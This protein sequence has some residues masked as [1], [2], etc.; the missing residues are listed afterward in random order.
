MSDSWIYEG[1][2]NLWSFHLT[3]SGILI[4]LITVLYSFLLNKREQYLSYIH[5]SRISKGPIIKKRLTLTQKYIQDI[6]KVIQHCFILLIISLIL[7]AISI[8]TSRL[9]T[10]LNSEKIIYIIILSITILWLLFVICLSYKLIK[11]YRED[12]KI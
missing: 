9:R 12:S 4:T 3:I 11:R 1:L 7:A 6:K 5:D 2:N 8:V 10:I